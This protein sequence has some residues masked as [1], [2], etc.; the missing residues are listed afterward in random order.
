MVPHEAI[1]TAIGEQSTHI[2]AKIGQAIFA[3]VA[4]VESVLRHH[5]RTHTH[6]RTPSLRDCSVINAQ[7]L[8]E[9][10]FSYLGIDQRAATISDHFA[11]TDE[12]RSVVGIKGLIRK[13]PLRQAFH[14]F[15]AC[16]HA[17]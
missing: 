3:A 2:A 10:V 7:H 5:V 9:L 6:T 1:Q 11:I 12:F 17:T 13:R 15:P 14:I 4:A 16:L 8:V